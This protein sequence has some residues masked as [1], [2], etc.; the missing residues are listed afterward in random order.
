M[1]KSKK[2]I[3][4][5]L[6]AGSI[7]ASV[8]MIFWGYG[9]D[10][11]YQILMSYRNLTGDTVLGTMWE[12]HQTSSF[13]CTGLLWIYRMLTGGFT[14]AVI[15]L[16]VCGTILHLFV[17]IY[18]YKVLMK[19]VRSE[20]AFLLS[21]IYYNMLPKQIILPD[22]SL[23]QVWFFT[24]MILYLFRYYCSGLKK[25]YL[26]L[27]GLALSLETLAYPSMVLHFIPLLLFIFYCSGKQKWKDSAAAAVTCLACGSV[28]VLYFV[29]RDRSISGLF[30]TLSRIVAG[31]KTHHVG[32]D[33]EKWQALFRDIWIF[34]GIG[35][36]IFGVSY[37]T[38]KLTA[39]KSHAGKNAVRLR[40]ANT[41]I[42]LSCGVQLVLWMGLN[43]GY[44]YLHV[45][46]FIVLMAGMICWRTEGRAKQKQVA[47]AGVAAVLLSM[48]AICSLSNLRL[49]VSMAHAGAGTI[50]AFLLGEQA[51]HRSFTGTAENKKEHKTLKN[52]FST[53]LILFC[54][55]VIGAKGYTLRGGKDF[56]NIFQSKARILYGPAAGCITNFDTAQ[57]YN[58]TYETWEQLE[59]SAPKL[60]VVTET[61]LS[62][63][64]TQYIYTG[65]EVCHYSI[66]DP[67]A[68][69]ERL[70]EYWK[71]YPG[72]YPDM[73]AVDCTL[74]KLELESDS[75][76][77]QFIEN[78]FGYTDI[79][80][81]PFVRIYIR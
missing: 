13:L 60:L 73:I 78:D 16:R 28:Y 6:I 49:S 5:I 11:E 4:I 14:G 39:K 8:K 63:M 2:W 44:E 66:I 9:L 23:M 51:N 35:A 75:W 22:F 12:P 70:L 71:L 53:V 72:K 68:Y 55:T 79:V 17:S 56:N 76:I 32:L 48:A 33:I 54:I 38:V 69:D 52:A 64:N 15:Y 34:A 7:L 19:D 59:A 10:E 29:V 74:G 25:R 24:L 20:Y 18:V 30:E 37:L 50:F 36:G 61:I 62:T 1:Q 40:T 31:D 47:A 45:H 41:A 58:R 27:A 42:L 26:I 65:A 46:V 3:Y 21:A 43:K 80:E 77:M 67:T 81:G 57:I